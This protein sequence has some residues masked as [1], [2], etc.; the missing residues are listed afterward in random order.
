MF[1]ITVPASSA[2]VGPG[3]DSA[4][5]AL[6]RYL[7]LTVEKAGDWKFSHTNDVVPEAEHYK[8]HYIYIT[9]HKIADWYNCTLQ[10]CHIKMHS[11]IPLARG[12]GSSASAIVAS[13]ELVN[14]LCHLQLT[15]DEKLALAVKI[16]GHPDNVAAALLGGFV[17]SVKMGEETSY[18]KLPSLDMDLV[19]YIPSFE[20][21][22]EDSRKVLPEQFQMKDAATASGISNLMVSSLLTGDYKL[23]GKMMESDLFHESYRAKLIPN[24]YELRSHARELG[25]FGTV[26]SGAGPTM[27]SFVPEGEGKRIAQEM[28]ELFPD[29][30][31]AALTIDEAGLT[32]KSLKERGWDKTSLK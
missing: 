26:I 1:E 4:G 9:A 2:N 18:K 24:Y 20:L 15:E 17:I 19:V 13:I 29:Y 14:Q 27:I 23:A 31:I 10:P 7:T 28:K 32:V 16:E 11:E 8:D 30:D 22:T 5:I 25:A 12:L 3:F 21:K 6:S